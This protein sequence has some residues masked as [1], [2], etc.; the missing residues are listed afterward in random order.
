MLS[1]Q[2]LTLAL[3]AATAATS[4]SK[5]ASLGGANTEGIIPY[6]DYEAAIASAGADGVRTLTEER[7][8]DLTLCLGI[9]LTGECTRWCYY[10]NRPQ[11]VPVKQRLH[12]LS[13]RFGTATECWFYKCVA[14]Y[15][16][17]CSRHCG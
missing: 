7:L 4:P 12:A 6:E 2:F 9:D 8:C 14:A 10:R 3:A 11:R 1:Y 5:P 13:A 16:P 15:K 17:Y